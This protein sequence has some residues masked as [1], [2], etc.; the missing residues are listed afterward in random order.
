MLFEYVKRGL[1]LSND[2]F[3]TSIAWYEILRGG[4]AGSTVWFSIISI[5]NGARLSIVY[6]NVSVLG[7][8]RYSL[9]LLTEFKDG[10]VSQSF[11]IHLHVL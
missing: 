11:C 1:R 5:S 10:S 6:V 2:S 9:L 4:L 3:T 8:C 7:W